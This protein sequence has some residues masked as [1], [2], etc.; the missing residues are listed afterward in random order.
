MKRLIVLLIALVLGFM[1]PVVSR[2]QG[3]LGLDVAFGGIDNMAGTS[4]LTPYGIRGAYFFSEKVNLGVGLR[5]GV[6]PTINAKGK[7]WMK[8]FHG[9]LHVEYLGA[10]PEHHFAVVCSMGLGYIAPVLPEDKGAGYVATELALRFMVVGP[11]Y[12][13]VG[14]EGFQMGA[15]RGRLHG[16]GLGVGWTF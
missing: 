6:A 7:E 15:N 1:T 14:Y 4:S 11:L 9:G 12:V 8:G 13:Q 5:M 3:K 16:L 2:A 10:F